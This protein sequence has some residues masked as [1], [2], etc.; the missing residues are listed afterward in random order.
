MVYRGAFPGPFRAQR[1]VLYQIYY[2]TLQLYVFYSSHQK[3][4]V[5]DDEL[6]QKVQLQSWFQDHRQ[7]Y[8]VVVEEDRDETEDK[9][10]NAG[11]S[12]LRHSAIV[13]N[14]STDT[15][16]DKE[17]DIGAVTNREEQIA[18]TV[19]H[20]ME[21]VVDEVVRGGSDN[22]A[23]HSAFDDSEDDDY[24]RAVMICQTTEKEV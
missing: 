2:I 12:G 11:G 10:Y 5:S 23:I 13:I 15:E 22:E 17:E 1:L 9:G 3:Q 4:R 24:R 18:G 8:W 7:R 16:D 19:G 20:G 14:D 21:M 6:F